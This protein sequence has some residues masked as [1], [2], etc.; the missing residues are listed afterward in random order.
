MKI[1]LPA[2]QVLE[3]SS[4]SPGRRSNDLLPYLPE[5]R[6]DFEPLP[7]K[8]SELRMKA[9]IVPLSDVECI[10]QTI[11]KVSRLTMAL[12]VVSSTDQMQL[13][14][15][16][17]LAH[18]RDLPQQ[19]QDEILSLCLNW[20]SS[21]WDEQD[22]SR[23]KDMTVREILD[24]RKTAATSA[25]DSRSISCPRFVKHVGLSRGAVIHSNIR[26]C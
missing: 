2:V 12:V 9:A 14:P 8:K 22:F 4:T 20:T 7:H 21:I 19:A 26:Q 5:F 25:Q 18:D 13:D 1:Q 10:T 17:L 24:K 3:I 6:K 23:V 15:S 11:F 16:D